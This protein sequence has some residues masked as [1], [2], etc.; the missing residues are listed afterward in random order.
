V[1]ENKFL[2]RLFGSNRHEVAGEWRRLH[3][4]E[5]NDLY[6]SRNI[7]R[8]IKSRRMRCEEH[9]EPTRE[10]RDLHK[11]VVGKSGGK[12]PFGRHRRKCDFDIKTDLQEVGCGGMDWI[13]LAQVRDRWKVL[14][15]AVM[16]LQ[17][18][19]NAGNFLTGRKPVSFSRWTL[20]HGVNK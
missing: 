5:L 15:K 7:V 9:E 10:R 11:V 17:V 12:R 2:R 13:E 1:C 8:V 16:K 3:D 6:S 14:E 20:F 4:E 18:P 19:I